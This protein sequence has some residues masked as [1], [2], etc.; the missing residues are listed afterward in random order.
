[1]R[2]PWWKH[3]D[4]NALCDVCGFKRKSSQT[5]RRWDG[6]Q[7]C[8]PVVKQGC[9]EPRHPQDFIRPIPDQQALPWTR[10]DP[11]DNFLNDKCSYAGIQGVAGCGIAGC[12]I[13]GFTLGGCE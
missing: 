13:T 7:V 9:W 8:S 11:Q 3:S 5:I 4:W 2:T 10:P 1:M 6:L 12:A